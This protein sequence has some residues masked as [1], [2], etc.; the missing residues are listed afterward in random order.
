M[1]T[2]R[3]VLAIG[4]GVAIIAVMHVMLEH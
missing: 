1:E 4:L 2:A 3:Q